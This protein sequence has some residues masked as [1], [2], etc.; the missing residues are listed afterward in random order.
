MNSLYVVHR[1]Y[2]S[3]YSGNKHRV[4]FKK[5]ARNVD[6]I[7]HFMDGDGNVRQ[8]R[9]ILVDHLSNIYEATEAE[10]R[11]FR[12]GYVEFRNQQEIDRKYERMLMMN[13]RNARIKNKDRRE[14]REYYPHT[15]F[16]LLS[17]RLHEFLYKVWEVNDIARKLLKLNNLGYPKGSLRNI[18]IS[19]STQEM[20]YTLGNKDTVMTG[21][22]RWEKKGRQQGKYGKILRKVLVE[23]IPNYKIKDSELEKL[24]NHL[25]A[26]Q[27]K[28]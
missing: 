22:D 16:Q 2:P 1:T 23:Q 26:S 14:L 24:V 11:R 18:T 20:T 21:N 6:G 17:T 13:S 10:K 5:T 27:P 8:R 9:G 4:V 25:K 28:R 15:E 12:A 19:K 3:S 7:F